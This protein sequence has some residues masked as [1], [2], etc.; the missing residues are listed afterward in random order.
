MVEFN[1][2][3]TQGWWKT[4]DWEYK[5][6]GA[7]T[8]GEVSYVEPSYDLRA[9][10]DPDPVD[11]DSDGDGI[12]DGADDQDND[13]WSNFVEMQLARWRSGYRVHPFNPCL[14]DPHAR[15]CSRWIPLGRGALRA[16]R[17]R[18]HDDRRHVRHGR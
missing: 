5:P 4:I 15:T 7:A 13:G 10:S 1:Y 12:L 11:P 9:F 18:R 17:H 6:H 2:T 8:T 16:L 3:G 14:P